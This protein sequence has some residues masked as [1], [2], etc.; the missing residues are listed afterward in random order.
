[1]EKRHFFAAFLVCA[2]LLA[3]GLDLTAQSIQ[4]LRGEKV[5]LEV[6]PRQVKGLA[7][8]VGEVVRGHIRHLPASSLGERIAVR[9]R[10]GLKS[11]KSF[12][13]TERLHEVVDCIWARFS[14]FLQSV[15]YKLLSNTK[16]LRYNEISE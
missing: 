15:R 13:T 1:M 10:D 9:C 5:V 11:I 2:L 4:E 7:T 8:R 6:T 16:K 3:G 14:S 12:K